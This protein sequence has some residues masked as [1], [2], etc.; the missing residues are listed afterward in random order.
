LGCHRTFS[1]S[2]VVDHRVNLLDDGGFAGAP[3]RRESGNTANDMGLLGGDTGHWLDD[4]ARLAQL[5]P[6]A[7]LVYSGRGAPSV[8]EAEI[9]GTG[10]DPSR[11]L[12]NLC[13]GQLSRMQE[14]LPES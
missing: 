10:L 14:I 12:M 13:P 3:I 8:A 7:R 1:F 11:V 9:R 2:G 5:F 6:Q 4:L